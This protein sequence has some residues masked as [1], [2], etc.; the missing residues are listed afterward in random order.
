LKYQERENLAWSCR[1]S[2]RAGDVLQD[3]QLW[4]VT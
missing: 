3:L 4:A 2:T 1:A